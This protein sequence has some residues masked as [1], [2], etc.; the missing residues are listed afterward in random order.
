[1]SNHNG[2][3]IQKRVIRLG[4][5]LG[6][7]VGNPLIGPLVRLSNGS[8]SPAYVETPWFEVEELV[9]ESDRPT[10]LPVAEADSNSVA[11]SD[12]FQRL[13]RNAAIIATNRFKFS[14]LLNDTYGRP[15]VATVVGGVIMAAALPRGIAD[16]GYNETRTKFTAAFRE[17]AN[18]FQAGIV[19]LTDQNK[20]IVKSSDTLVLAQHVPINELP[21]SESYPYTR[22][23]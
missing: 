10:E 2:L 23:F 5:R 12:I 15:A 18:D 14:D 20:K 17:G 8:S 4:L 22:L 1:M 9:D 3:G 6:Q 7:Q 19:S 13:K 16:L 21:E 11:M